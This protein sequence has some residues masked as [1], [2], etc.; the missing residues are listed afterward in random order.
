M[1]LSSIIIF[2]IIIIFNQIWL[3]CSTAS[4]SLS[5]TS[6][7]S[8]INSIFT[9]AGTGTATSA[10]LGGKATSASFNWPRGI[11]QDSVGTIFLSQDNANCIV[12]F[13]VNG[14]VYAKGGV[15]GFTGNTGNGGQATSALISRPFCMVTDTLGKFYY[16]ELGNHVIR[17]ISTSGIIS[18]YAGTGTASS[19]GDNGK[20]TAATLNYPIGLWL[21]TDGLMYMTNFNAF[22]V[23]VIN[24]ATNIITAFA[25]NIFLSVSNLFDY[26]HYVGAGTQSFSGDGGKATSAQFSN[27]QNVHLDSTTGTVYIADPCKSCICICV[28]IFIL[29]L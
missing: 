14:N 17:T 12:Y 7:R 24:T 1:I 29:F 19:T 18:V 2:L 26:V 23:K 22:N 4:P 10:G 25:G 5:P 11:W 6:V 3:S 27:M 13:T 21:S 9:V 20:S 16:A 28:C 8:S 15:C